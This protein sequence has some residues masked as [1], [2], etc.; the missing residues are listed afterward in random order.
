[1]LLR[2]KSGE[3]AL[4]FPCDRLIETG[5]SSLHRGITI[6]APPDVI[7]RWLCQMRVASYSYGRSGPRTLTP[8][9]DE[10]AVGQRVMRSFD[11]IDFERP[12]HLT[13]R[14]RE[15]APESRFVRDV[16]VSYLIVPRDADTCRVLVKTVVNHR[17]G[18]L[19]WLMRLLLPWGDLIMM[20]KQLHSFKQLSEQVA[21]TR[22]DR[23]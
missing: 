5:D 11:L 16:V 22:D 12:R 21:E 23:P 2:T 19:G 13:L 8:G 17:V 18:P 1:M 10:L 15:H 9:L 3:R 4:P 14:L 20:R 6:H 7:F